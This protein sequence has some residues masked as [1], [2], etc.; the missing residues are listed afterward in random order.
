MRRVLLGLL[1]LGLLA[2]ALTAYAYHEATSDPI[3]RR[4]AI[5][6]ADWPQGEPPLRALLLSDVHVGGPDM[7]PERLARI[8][9]RANALAPD[10][11]LLAGDFISD[12]RSGTRDY[13]YPEALAPLAAL[14]PRLG[15]IA[16]LGNHDHWK[17]AG[18]A[19]AAL[20]GVG[21]RVLDNDAVAAGPLA[22]GGLDDAFTDHADLPLTLSR[23]GALRGA[24]ILLSH[25]PDPFAALP[26]E[27]ALMLAGHTHCG[28]V[29]P[30]LIGPLTTYPKHGERYG[31]GR[32]DE[33]G[34]TLVVGAGIGTSIL[35]LRIGAVPDMWLIRIG[36][37]TR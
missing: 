2:L 6:L 10:I 20:E 1:A 3:V 11:V 21:V 13:P 28:Q 31:C 23:L 27:V 12:K 19:R 9:V 29:A 8:V 16:V 18:E 34:K 37:R 22:V 5:E 4:T 14:K 15:T 32:S 26:V 35:P 24:K 30:P 33:A 17:D 36:P 7:P 25:S